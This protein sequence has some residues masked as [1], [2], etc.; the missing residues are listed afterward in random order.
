MNE[1]EEYKNANLKLWNHL[2]KIHLDSAFYDKKGFMLGKNTLQKI[3][4]SLLPPL[5]ELNVLHLQ[6]HFGLD[7]MSMTRMGAKVTGVDFSP[8]AVDQARSLASRLHLNTQ[9]ICCD[10]YELENHLSAKYDL[11][12]ASYGI[13]SWLTDLSKWAGIIKAFLRPDGQFLLVDFHPFLY[14]LDFETGKIVDSTMSD[15]KPK[16]YDI[17]SSYTGDKLR[18]SHVEYAMNYSISQVVS[19]LLEQSLL[20]LAYREFDYSPYASFPNAYER[21]KKEYVVKPLAGI[22]IPYVYALKFGETY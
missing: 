11:I 2:A 12:F 1:V 22:K 14:S 6:C 8:I 16:L 18:E 10:I 19:P 13:T 7:S 3:E 20:L 15:G 21:A 9:F 4:L 17:E 5:Q